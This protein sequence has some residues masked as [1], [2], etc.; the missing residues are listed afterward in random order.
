MPAFPALPEAIREL[1]SLGTGGFKEP[2]WV[3]REDL[4][5]RRGTASIDIAD[6]QENRNLANRFY[7]WVSDQP[8]GL[9]I[10]HF[11]NLDSRGC[12][13][14]EAAGTREESSQLLLPSHGVKLVSFVNPLNAKLSPLQK[15]HRHDDEQSATVL[16][17]RVVESLVTA[18]RR[19]VLFVE[20]NAEF[21][22]TTRAAFLQPFD[23]ATTRSV[24]GAS[25]L[26][27]TTRYD[28]VLLDYDLADGKGTEVL[29]E[30]RDWLSQPFVVA[31]S[32]HDRGNTALLKAGAHD[33]CNKMEFQHIT[34]RLCLR[35]SEHVAATRRT[36]VMFRP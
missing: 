20:D 19:R 32:S 4:A 3:F 25:A 26:L 24:T 10:T 34:E 7:F 28:F 31:T 36:R 8:V 1:G 23:V 13:Y 5:F 16:S 11:A 9:V 22:S 6:I 30:A 27:R 12:V 17:R 2:V 29:A 21:T 14:F 35:S 33:T 15:R 18:G